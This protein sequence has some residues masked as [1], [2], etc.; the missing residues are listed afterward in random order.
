MAQAL[1]V[2]CSLSV[3]LTACAAGR[4][5]LTPEQLG[6]VR[7][8]AQ[9]CMRAHPTVERYEVDRFGSV[10]AYYRTTSGS[11]TAATDP[12]FTCVRN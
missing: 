10:T 9:E 11:A 5:P 6:Q 4:E 8:R 3:L 12:F 2:V 1:V 7:A